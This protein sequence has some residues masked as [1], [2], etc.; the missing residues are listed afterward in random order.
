MADGCRDRWI[1]KCMSK[2]TNILIPHSSGGISFEGFSLQVLIDATLASLSLG[3]EFLAPRTSECTHTGHTVLSSL[4]DANS[5]EN[6]TQTDRW[7]HGAPFAKASGFRHNGNATQLHRCEMGAASRIL[8]YPHQW[9]V[10][11]RV[12]H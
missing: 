9:L 12:Y 7:Y 4:R 10:S 1:D 2:Q 11:G 8:I 3:S 5:A 6:S